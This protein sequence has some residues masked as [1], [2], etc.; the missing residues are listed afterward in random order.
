MDI[1][2][3]VPS[4]FSDESGLIGRTDFVQHEIDTG[5]SLPVHSAPYRVSA[6]ERKVIAE[7]VS[8]MEAAGVVRPSVSPWSSPVVLTKRSDGRLRFCVDYRRLNDK[9]S[10][11]VY[12]LPRMDDVLER[13]GGA[14]VFT[15][16]DLA[17]GYWQ[18][19]IA[20]RDQPKTAFVTPDG[21]YEFRRMPFGLCNAPATFQR[22]VNRA[23]TGLKWTACLVY[24][25]D[26]LVYGRDLSEHNMRLRLVLKALGEAGLTL[27]L[28]KCLFA[29]DSVKYLG[30]LVTAEGLSPNPEK[31]QDIVNFPIPKT[32][33]QLRGFLGL[34]SFYRRFVPSFANISRPLVNLLKKGADLEWELEEQAAFDTLKRKLSE[35]PVLIHFQEDSP[36]EV[37]ID[38]SGLGLGAVLCQK[39][40]GAIHPVTFISRHLTDTES[41]YHANEL[42]CLALIWALEK[43]HSYVYG[44]PHFTMF[45]NS[46]ALVWLKSKK[47]VKGKLARWVLFLAD[48]NFDLIHVKGK[49]NIVPNVL[50]RNPHGLPEET[51]LLKDCPF[52]SCLFI[53]EREKLEEIRL[54]QRCDSK[55]SSLINQLE[56]PVHMTKRLFI[57]G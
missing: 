21:L 33:S 26:I 56:N 55:M 39:F 4:C 16:L 45:S 13:L 28:K 34:A 23:L 41:R 37:H 35:P 42:E 12:P 38:A 24:L 9:T 31:V 14:K 32:I 5:T 22:L 48:D 1:L 18:V 49:R 27:N 25:D 3:S 20:E 8:E 10:K 30:H 19:P 29:A 44:R 51:D 50:S 53:S 52:P 36:I 46:S 6:A 15:T 17:N 57:F 7:Q 2:A 47:E 40:Q 54:N 11:D 43:L